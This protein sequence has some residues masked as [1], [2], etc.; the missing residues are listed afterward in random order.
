MT[1]IPQDTGQKRSGRKREGIAILCLVLAVAVLTVLEIRVTP[2]DTGL[3]LS[4]TVL[5]FILINI[6]LLLLLTLL[7]LVFRN[8]AKLYYER[9]NNIL[10]SKIKTRLTVAFIVLALLP[11]TVLFFFS[12]QFISTSIA[13]WFNAP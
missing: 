7:L 10:G 3:P 4:S 13:F 12:I 6:N 1:Q 11:T 9:K 5:M 2:F 8:L